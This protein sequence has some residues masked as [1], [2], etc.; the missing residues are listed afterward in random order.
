MFNFRYLFFYFLTLFSGFIFA[1]DFTVF[2]LG[3]SESWRVNYP[4][5][6]AACDAQ[7]STNPPEIWAVGTTPTG[8]A[9]CISPSDW[10]SVYQRSVSCDDPLEYNYDLQQC[11]LP[12]EPEKCEAGNIFTRF[13][14]ATKVGNFYIPN[15]PGSACFNSC[16]YDG[17]TTSGGGCRPTANGTYCSA[18]FVSNGEECGGESGFP[19]ELP[20]TDP[21]PDDK[22]DYEGCT[23]RMQADGSYMWDCNPKADQGNCPDGFLIGNDGSTCYRDPKAPPPKDPDPTNPGDGDG[24]GDGTGEGSEKGLAKDSTLKDIG[25]KI[26]TTNTKLTGID[27][28]IDT[29][30]TLLQGIIDAVGNIPGGG[31]GSNNPGDGEGEGSGSAEGVDNCESGRCD[32]GDERGDP[33]GGEVRSFS[34]SLTAAMT[35]MKNSPLGNSIGNI[36]FP[37]GGSCPT[38]STSINIGIGSIPIDFTEHCNFWQQISPILSAVFLAF[39]AILAVRVFL[40]A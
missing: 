31:G 21:D 17:T 3:G 25:T 20:P 37:S 8:M 24:N 6:Q 36:Q 33:F 32:F 2:R 14:P 22:N 5:I 29:S 23:R 16:S 34:E 10:T 11:A 19:D 35:G 1:A 26:D 38:G 18:S 9:G 39:W 15:A 40:S 7:T 30:N 13:F 27:G 28:K 12:E 4:T